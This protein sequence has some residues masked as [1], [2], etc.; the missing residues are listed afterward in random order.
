M[1]TVLESSVQTVHCSAKN[2]SFSF[3]FYCHSSKQKLIGVSE[4]R[5]SALAQLNDLYVKIA[6]LYNNASQSGVFVLGT[7]ESL[8]Q[9][10]WT[11]VDLSS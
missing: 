6:N 11:E 4:I 1:D 9:Y 8:L 2:H 10:S 7:N 3:F 5:I